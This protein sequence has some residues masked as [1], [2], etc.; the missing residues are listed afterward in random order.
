MATS[1]WRI[2][3]YF[4]GV[5]F[6]YLFILG[7]L[8]PVQVNESSSVTDRSCWAVPTLVTPPMARLDLFKGRLNGVLLTSLYVTTQDTLTIGHLGTSDGRVLQVRLL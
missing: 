1:V 2:V 4:G 3:G 6:Y 8:F 7:L 5:S